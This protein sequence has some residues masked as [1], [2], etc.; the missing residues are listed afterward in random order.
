M[1]KDVEMRHVSSP[2]CFST[3]AS[4][5]SV[6]CLEILSPVMSPQAIQSRP[7]PDILQSVKVGFNLLLIQGHGWLICELAIEPLSL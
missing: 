5:N 1:G 2:I 7:L 3:S 4:S 6:C